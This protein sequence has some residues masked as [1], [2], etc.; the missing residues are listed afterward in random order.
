MTSRI[1]APL[2]LVLDTSASM[3]SWLGEYEK[4]VTELLTHL[5]RGI[6]ADLFRVSVL[7]FSGHVEV[8]LPLQEPSDALRAWSDTHLALGDKTF[9]AP[10]LRLLLE[11]SQQDIDALKAASYSVYRPMVFFITDGEPMDGPDLEEAMIEIEASPLRIIALAIALID[12]TVLARIAIRGI[13]AVPRASTLPDAA[14]EACL[15]MMLDY[16]DGASESTQH[17]RSL[18]LFLPRELL[19]VSPEVL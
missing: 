18:R 13:A 11:R 10:V 3:G 19:Q 1:A 2:Y 12:P 4:M 17:K 7:T 16:V 8:A 15:R 14:L 5:S 9:Y 6:G